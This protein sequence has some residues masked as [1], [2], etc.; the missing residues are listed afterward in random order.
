[1]E[2]DPNGVGAKEG[3]RLYDDGHYSMGKKKMQSNQPRLMEAVIRGKKSWGLWLDQWTD[4]ISEW[5]FT[6]DEIFEEFSSKGIKIPESF[7]K[8]FDNRLDKK[9]RIRN[10][11]Y[12]EE[13]RGPGSSVG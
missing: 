9:K 13:L 12:L 10:E 6:R 8:D 11:K 2:S 4:G 7:V 3:F 1:V 5:S